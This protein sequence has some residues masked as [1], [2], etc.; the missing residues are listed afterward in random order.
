M[1]QI[2]KKRFGNERC[3]QEGKVA[4][5][6]WSYCPVQQVR[7]VSYLADSNLWYAC[8]A[9]LRILITASFSLCLQQASRW[10]YNV[11]KGVFIATQLNSTQLTQ[12]NSV[13]PSQSCFC[14]W[15]HD[16]QTESTWSLRSL[17]GD[18]CWRCERVDNSTS[19]GVELSCVT[20]DTSPTQLNSTSSGVELSCVAI[21]WPSLSSHLSIRSFVY[22]QTCECNILKTSGPVL[23]STGRSNPQGHDMKCSTLEIRGWSCMRPK[24]DLEARLINPLCRVGF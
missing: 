18:S 7:T 13:Q 3:N 15:R 12:L 2:E 22:Y 24:I 14:L 21:N 19:S 5:E 17:I 10:T 8:K 9:F 20:I 16:L 1:L 6:N 11:I 23:M 4:S